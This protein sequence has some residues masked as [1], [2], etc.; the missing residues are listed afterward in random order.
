MSYQY[1]SR[2]MVGRAVWIDKVMALPDGKL[3][4]TTKIVVNAIS[5]D[6]ASRG[7]SHVQLTKIWIP[8]LAEYCGLCTKTVA[9][10]LDYLS[11]VGAINKEIKRERKA[12]GATVPR[13]WASFT[14]Q[15]YPE[16]VLALPDRPQRKDRQRVPI[17]CPHCNEYHS[18]QARTTY[19][20]MGCSSQIEELTE[21]KEIKN[22]PP[23]AGQ[24]ARLDEL[25]ETC[26]TV[27][28]VGIPREDATRG[29]EAAAFKR[30]MHIARGVDGT[31]EIF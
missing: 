7:I 9:H 15:F 10:H 20:C 13:I 2:Q 12:D 28:L 31:W 23:G 29:Q 4:P 18:L 19:V 8:N 1:D 17:R 21:I 6:F 16:I 22:Q 27:S 25:V 3:A 24:L 26:E 11:S 30:A 14:S 5:Y